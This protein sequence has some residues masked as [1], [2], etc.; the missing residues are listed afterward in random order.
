[1]DWLKQFSP[2]REGGTERQPIP[3]PVA[4]FTP[5]EPAL[6]QRAMATGMAY[7]LAMDSFFGASHAIRP[8]GERHTHSFRVQAVFVTDSVD[9]N[10]M[11]CGFR[12]VSDLVDAEAK[13][14]VNRFINEI[15]PFDIVQPTGENLAT[16][17]YRN[18]LTALAESMPGGPELVSV[19]LWENPTSSV[20]VGMWRA[21]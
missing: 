15:K 14:Y 5:S 6:V 4:G 9:E 19:T 8:S 18:L 3:L 16:I 21:A 11:I 1:M 17:I 7:E 13:R 2:Q 12:E 10:G 20:R